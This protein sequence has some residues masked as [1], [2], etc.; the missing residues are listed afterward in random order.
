MQA[1]FFPNGDRE[2]LG[3]LESMLRN[4]YKHREELGLTENQ[5][6]QIEEEIFCYSDAL[7]G[8]AEAQ[9]QAQAA[10]QAK[11]NAK[12]AITYSLREMNRM[13]QANSGIDDE[14]KE[15]MGLPVYA[16]TKERVAPEE[17]S[18]LI[19]EPNANGLNRLKWSTGDNK[20]GTMYMVES[21]VDGEWSVVGVT[22][23]STYDHAGQIPGRTVHYRVRA[24]R[25]DEV[26]EI[27]NVATAYAGN[28]VVAA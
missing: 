22:T 15:T 6:D 28:A 23:K 4:I 26:S 5:F 13:I 18:G 24:Q 2:F 14:L 25:R 3:Y 16:K 12:A 19:V 11:N 8:H 17:P 9:A 7:H 21:L 10:T 27:S 20:Y 1:N